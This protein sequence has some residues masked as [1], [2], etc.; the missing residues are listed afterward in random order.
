MMLTKREGDI[1]YIQEVYDG[2][3][4]PVKPKR[5]LSKKG[6]AVVLAVCMTFSAALGIGGGYY[7]GNNPAQTSGAKVN[8]IRTSTDAPIASADNQQLTIAQ[9]A[10]M[11]ADSVVEITTE[12]VKTSMIYQQYVTEGAGSGVIITKDGYI[13]TN[14]HVI[15]GASKISIRLHN[16]KVMEATLVGAD[17]KTDLAIIKVNANDLQPAVMG[18]SAKLVV[19][20]TAIA[21]GNPLGSLGGTVTNGIISALSR[22]IQVGDT[23]MT[24]LQTNAAIN[25]GNS[26]G[27]LFNDKGELIGVVS[28]KSSGV[29]IEG[30]GFAIPIDTAKVVIDQ[31]RTSGYVKGRVDT[32]LNLLDIS[33]VQDAFL[34][35]VSRTG[36]Y[37]QLVTGQNA[38]EAGFKS[39]DRII[40]LNGE[41]VTNRSDFNQK[42]DA[43]KVG[44]SVTITIVRGYSTHH[45]ALKLTEYVPR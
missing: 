17:A 39:G 36:L 24:L 43:H 33:N 8:G 6:V 19:G 40:A 38:I 16:G 12:S 32:G 44:D 27:G 37:V 31:L 18:S 26:G 45:I 4:V 28:A 11:V 41:E 1:S 10:A 7:L 15:E 25:P 34:Y 21:V 22:D 42:L 20:E 14:N 30:L 5:R 23:T 9:V 3:Y 13:V 2:V 35:R 29:G